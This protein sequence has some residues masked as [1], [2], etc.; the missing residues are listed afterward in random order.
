MLHKWAKALRN[1]CYTRVL[2]RQSV[3][4]PVLLH[5]SVASLNLVSAWNTINPKLLNSLS[6]MQQPVK[7]SRRKTVTWHHSVTNMN[8]YRAFSF[9]RDPGSN[10]IATVTS[11]N[12]CIHSTYINVYRGTYTFQYAA[13]SIVIAQRH[14]WRYLLWGHFQLPKVSASKLTQLIVQ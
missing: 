4:M 11:L 7:Q 3:A 6:T 12:S 1:S 14:T 9:P 8:M 10:D 5:Q 13:V 2:L